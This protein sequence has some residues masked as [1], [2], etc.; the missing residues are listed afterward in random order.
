M[1]E[2][3]GTESDEGAKV[4]RKES[5]AEKSAREQPDPDREGPH[6]DDQEELKGIKGG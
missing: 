4:E 5:D 3:I 6:P 1:E 2:K